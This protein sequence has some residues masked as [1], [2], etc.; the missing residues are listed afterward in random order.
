MSQKCEV[1]IMLGAGPVQ[2]GAP[3]QHNAILTVATLHRDGRMTRH[4]T[5]S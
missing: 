5:T 3:G 4:Q 2:D 1:G